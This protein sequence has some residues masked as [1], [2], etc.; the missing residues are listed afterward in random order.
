MIQA[1]HWGRRW[2][3][4][5]QGTRNL[6]LQCGSRK[7]WARPVPEVLDP[8]VLARRVLCLTGTGLRQHPHW[9]LSPGQHTGCSAGVADSEGRSQVMSLVSSVLHGLRSSWGIFMTL[10]PSPLPSSI[11]STASPLSTSKDYKTFRK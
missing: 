8:E 4:E 2:G 7:D 6:R 1:G 9:A 3:A 10:T 5:K 11:F